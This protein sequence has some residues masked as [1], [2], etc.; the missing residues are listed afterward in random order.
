MKS[1]SDIHPD[2][3]INT[4]FTCCNALLRDFRSSATVPHLLS[5]LETSTH[6]V[7][8]PFGERY[9]LFGIKRNTQFEG[10]GQATECDEQP[11][12]F[13]ITKEFLGEAVGIMGRDYRTYTEALIDLAFYLDRLKTLR[14]NKKQPIIKE[15]NEKV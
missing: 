14:D 15:T 6:G 1:C 13:F 8:F 7:T 4:G 10:Y 9:D 12:S 3:Q 11:W 5:I 2:Q